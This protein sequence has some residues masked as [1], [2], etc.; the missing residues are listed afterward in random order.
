[1]KNTMKKRQEKERQRK[2]IHLQLVSLM[3]CNNQKPFGTEINNGWLPEYLKSD[4]NFF[5]I[6][7]EEDVGQD[8]YT[9]SAFCLL[10]SRKF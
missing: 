7:E 3:Q 2:K 6:L 1:M 10:Y 4:P 5:D 9:L 8:R